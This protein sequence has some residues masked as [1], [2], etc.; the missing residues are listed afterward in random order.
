MEYRENGTKYKDYCLWGDRKISPYDYERHGLLK[1]IMSNKIV[2]SQ[3]SILQFVL[4]YYEKS[5]IFLLKYI[6]RLKH[7]KNYHAKN[8]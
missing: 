6:D 1:H 2:S 4:S 5:I 7:F 8:R 3:N